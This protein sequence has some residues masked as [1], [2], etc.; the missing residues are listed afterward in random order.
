M[1]A[2]LGPCLGGRAMIHFTIGGTLVQ[3]RAKEWVKLASLGQRLGWK[4]AR[5]G[6]N[7]GEIWANRATDWV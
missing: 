7:G 1:V 3:I 2:T 6:P 5:M 4:Q